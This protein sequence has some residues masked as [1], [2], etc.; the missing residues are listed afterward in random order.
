MTT[1]IVDGV[2]RY[3]AA[4]VTPQATA[5]TAPARLDL[6]AYQGDDLFLTLTFTDP[7]DAPLDLTGWVFRSQIRTAVADEQPIVTAEFTATVTA[8]VVVLHL[9]GAETTDLTPPSMVY[10]VQSVDSDG[11]ITTWVRG[12]VPVTQEVTR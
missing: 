10:D 5:V 8:N 7:D 3:A 11:R 9:T 4:V 2:T 12:S 6:P 1:R